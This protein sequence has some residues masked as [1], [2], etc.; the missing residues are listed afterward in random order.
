MH[1]TALPSS[2]TISVESL[3]AVLKAAKLEHDRLATW[4]D[5][6]AH[7]SFSQDASDLAFAITVAVRTVMRNAQGGVIPL[8][9]DATVSTEVAATLRYYASRELG[10]LA[11]L[12]A[13]FPDDDL[14]QQVAELRQALQAIPYTLRR[15]AGPAT[16]PSALIGAV[17]H[18]TGA[19]A[20]G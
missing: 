1:D 9:G 3:W 13:W 14:D 17:P 7:A 2:L 15:D 5:L 20:H 12:N 19:S 11:G 10:R 18:T 8:V 16:P 6:G 4:L